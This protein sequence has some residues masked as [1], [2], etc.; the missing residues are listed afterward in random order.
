MKK[1]FTLFVTVLTLAQSVS[2]G[3]VTPERAARSA[4]GL[5]GV[6]S[7]SVQENTSALRAA[8]RDGGEEP[9]YYIFNAPEGGWAIIAAEDRVNPVIAY[10]PKGKFDSSDLPENLIWWMNGVAEYIDIVRGS[11]ME[12]PA[13]VKAAWESL[14]VGAPESEKKELVTAKWTQG[15]PFNSMCP[16]VNGETS[17][18]ITGCVATAMAIIMQYNRWPLHGTGVI[19]GYT[20]SYT[21]TYIPPYSIDDHYYDW[22]LLSGEDVVNGSISKWTPEQKTEVAKLSYDCAVAV[23]MEFSSQG[24]GAAPEQ[25]AGAMKNNMSYS[26]SVTHLSRSSYTLDK[27]FAIIKNEI[28]QDRVVF[29]SGSG[30][31]GGHAFVC[32][33]YDTDGQKV[34]INWG[35]GNFDVNGFY[36]LDLT[37][38]AI[39]QFEFPDY[40]SA[41]IGIAPDTTQVSVDE[42]AGLSCE[43]VNG[44]YGIEPLVPA[45]MVQGAEVNFYLGWF[46]N[47]E[48]RDVTREF[49]VCLMDKDG[50]IRQDGWHLTMKFPAANGYLYSDKTEKDI[51]TVNPELT[52]YF[53]VYLKDYYDNWVPMVGNYDLF[54]DV[55]GLVC[56]VTQDPLIIVPDDCEAGQ[57][58]KL[59][60]SLGYSTVKAVKWNVNGE[61]IEGDV[62]KFVSGMN[63]I[64]ADVEYMDDSSGFI[65]RTLML[66]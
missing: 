62:V 65:C 2:A 40:Q 16:V 12:A 48:N 35:W 34:H 64:R 28:D 21:V 49:K 37:L 43:Y 7:V 19:G 51:L 58:V 50:N 26:E 55:D 3:L 61:D 54:P 56:G 30:D 59:S 27:W 11:D 31:G 44:F 8:G 32:D 13:S 52:D 57:D 24:S 63:E 10:S 47:H 36:T 60:L 25:V 6:R 17:R 9:E 4:R 15:D 23:E 33:G 20:T 5:L 53:K 14:P 39:Y 29:Y 46:V 45:D 22:D 42:K 18:S 1:I 38:P 66:E 41:V